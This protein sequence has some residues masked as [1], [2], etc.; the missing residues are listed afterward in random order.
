MTLRTRNDIGWYFTTPQYDIAK[1]T[2]EGGDEE[3]HVRLP[4][5]MARA[6]QE[7]TSTSTH[8]ESFHSFLSASTSPISRAGAL[9]EPLQVH[10]TIENDIFSQAEVSIV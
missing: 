10:V 5:W 9:F 7:L 8:T 1:E 6:F 4:E 2:E 3:Q